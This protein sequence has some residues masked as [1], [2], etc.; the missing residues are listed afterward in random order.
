MKTCITFWIVLCMSMTVAQTIPNLPVAL[1]A[2]TAEVWNDSI[3]YFGGSAD[4]NGSVRSQVVY[5]YGG[6]DWT[7]HDTI[8]DVAVWDMESVILGD[9]IYL[10]SGWP[11][12]AELVRK[13]NLSTGDWSYLSPSPNFRPWGC[14][15]EVVDSTIYLFHPFGIVYEYDPATDNWETKTQNSAAAT[16]GLSSTIY[17]GEIYLAGYNDS[18]LQKYS[19]S[20]DSWTPLA[21]MPEKLLS[22]VLTVINDK[23]YYAGGGNDE[24]PDNPSDALLFYDPLLDEWQY[25]QFRLNAQRQW[26]IDVTYQNKPYVLGGFDTTRLALDIVE[27]IVPLGPAV[28]ISPAGHSPSTFTLEQNYPNPFNPTTTIRYHL[29]SAANIQL[30]IYNV[31]GEVVRE[32]IRYSRQEAGS[33]Q[34]V[35]NGDNNLGEPVSSGMYFYRLHGDGFELSRRMILIR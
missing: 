30:H 1:G 15:A 22:G 3:Y 33:H 12:G 4:F 14:T 2:G 25:D 13:Y 29:A 31:Q 19:P 18:T 9:N 26:V 32:L 11:N 34:I 21:V 24:D 27:E 7:V 23:I 8:P 20:L 28:A 17:Q 35:W 16:F 6:T 5:K 10:M